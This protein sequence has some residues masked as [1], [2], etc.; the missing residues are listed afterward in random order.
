MLSRV[1]VFN[2][3]AANALCDALPKLANLRNLDLSN[4]GLGSNELANIFE[5]LANEHMG[6]CHLRSL[7]VSQNN[8]SPTPDAKS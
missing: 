2:K 5:A 3:Q 7:N 4:N 1:S 6:P 8:A